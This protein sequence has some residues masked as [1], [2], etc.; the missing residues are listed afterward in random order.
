MRI[1]RSVEQPARTVTQPSETRPATDPVRQPGTNGAPDDNF[2]V[3]GQN[4]TEAQNLGAAVEANS[5]DPNKVKNPLNKSRIQSAIVTGQ[6]L[7]WLNDETRAQS[8][9]VANQL[10]GGQTEGPAKQITAEQAHQALV[11]QLG[12]EQAEELL[13]KAGPEHAAGALEYINQAT[14]AADQ[15][16]RISD[17]VEAL[18]V[19]AKDPKLFDR[20]SKG[21]GIIQTPYTGNSQV[22]GTTPPPTAPRLP[23]LTKGIA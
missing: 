10:M 4:P 6:C 15:T 19:V 14:D 20:I 16:K 11:D 1:S 18:R 12:Q 23:I 21:H 5:N 17:A 8:D 22:G 3:G 2:A 9:A 7:N 13:K